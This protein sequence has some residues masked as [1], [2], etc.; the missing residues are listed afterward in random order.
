MATFH[1]DAC[2]YTGQVQDQPVSEKAKCPKCGHFARVTF[3]DADILDALTTPTGYDTLACWVPRWG[4]PLPTEHIG[5]EGVAATPTGRQ[6][7]LETI[8]HKLATAPTEASP[9][10]GKETPV[11]A[12]KRQRRE[13]FRG[14]MAPGSGEL[15][16]NA[17][18]PRGSRITR[19]LLFVLGTTCF[20][21]ICLAVGARYLAPSN[22]SPGSEPKSSEAGAVGGQPI[23][24]P[25]RPYYDDGHPRSPAVLP[26]P[27]KEAKTRYPP[28]AEN[29]T[30]VAMR[31]SPSP[32][33]AEQ[34]LAASIEAIRG[35]ADP[36]VAVAAFASGVAADPSNARLNEAYVN[37]MVDLGLAAAAYQ[38]ARFAVGLDPSYG[39]G[40]AVMAYV[41]FHHGEPEAAILDIAQ[42]IRNSPGNRFSQTVAGMLLA[43]Y[44]KNHDQIDLPEP[45]LQSLG[46]VRLAMDGQAGYIDAYDKAKAAYEVA[47]PQ[48][49]AAPQAPPAARPAE[50][51]AVRPVNVFPTVTICDTNNYVS[52]YDNPQPY[53]GPIFFGGYAYPGCWRGPIHRDRDRVDHA[54]H[55]PDQLRHEEPQKPPA[56]LPPPVV[57]DWKRPPEPAV[58]PLRS[59]PLLVERTFRAGSQESSGTPGFSPIQTVYHTG[60]SELTALSV[61]SLP[62]SPKNVSPVFPSNSIR[63]LRTGDSR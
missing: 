7:N 40:W 37:R 38:Q 3:S 36:S 51:E 11:S 52:Y 32:S 46:Q 33:P 4:P 16:A 41:D 25:S 13:G 44:D 43:W 26:T 47:P 6:A 1:C 48:Q 58:V 34:R 28:R 8:R 56:K 23:L 42:A 20:G 9:Q 30:I 57:R 50:A 19:I 5:R 39:L 29:E 12:E 10:A 21:L 31:P 49:A 35:A 62:V 24:E 53:Y 22:A 59:A 17:A 27:D 54:R 2:G 55:A 14:T 60:R 63:S 45:L 61:R 18:S 15:P